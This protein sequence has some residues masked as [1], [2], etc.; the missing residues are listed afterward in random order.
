MDPS[1][2]KFPILSYVMSQLSLKSSVDY[3]A[4]VTEIDIEQ[5]N[6]PQHHQQQEQEAD[7]VKQM[8]HLSHPRILGSMSHAISDVAQ[9]RSILQTLGPRPDHEAVD[10]AR[11]KIADIDS[12]LSNQLEEIV[13]S[14]R[15]DNVDRLIWR[16]HLADREKQC[17]D[18][19]ERERSACRAL[20]QLDEMHDAYQKLLREAE[21]RLVKIYDSATAEGADTDH[22]PEEEETNEEVIKI[23]QEAAM[24][25]VEL[26]GRQLRFLPEAFGRLHG[27]V[28]LNLSSNQLEVCKCFFFP[29][30]LMP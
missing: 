6:P 12:R 9:T 19:A 4:A 20:L 29:L 7:L 22:L 1:P 21:D 27:L 25:R 11:A 23:L 26:A 14:P 15:P 3:Q 30:L 16:S 18:E 28:V 24:E 17:R 8:P 2:R 13:L 10:A 5:P